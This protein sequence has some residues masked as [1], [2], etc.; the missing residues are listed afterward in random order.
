MSECDNC[1]TKECLFE[2]TDMA[3][4]SVL[5]GQCIKDGEE[6]HWLIKTHIP[7]TFPVGSK[8]HSKRKT[9][10]GWRFADEA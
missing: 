10:V 9:E 4:W 2:M 8:G 7:E 5:C 6:S 1:G 3:Y